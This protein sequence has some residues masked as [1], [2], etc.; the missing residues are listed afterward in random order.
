MTI[1]A[2]SAP[3]PILDEPIHYTAYLPPG[4]SAKSRRYP[5][6]YLL[7]GRGDTSAAWA[8]MA[9]DLDELITSGVLPPLVALMPDAPWS[10]RASWYVD[11]LYTGGSSDGRDSGRAVDSAL[12]RDLVR[13]VDATFRT[14]EDRAARLVGGYSMGGSGALRFALAHQQTFCAALVLSPAIY[15]PAPPSD[16]SIRA[17]GAFGMGTRLFSRARYDALNYP[18]A[19]AALDVDLATDLFISA[20]D[21]EHR[22]PGPE[23]RHDVSAEIA[24]LHAAASR[25]P[26]VTSQL[27]VVP[28]GHDWG[29]WRPAARQG[30]IYLMRRDRIG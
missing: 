28:G 17:S 7:H 10:N 29:V 5:T 30:L 1:V 16:S 25:T 14:I 6:V 27:V 12:T 11:S 3:S 9:P 15:V 20:G 4:Y 13:H 19:L 23:A 21:N 2:G 24:A 22:H 8:T 18:A 26:A